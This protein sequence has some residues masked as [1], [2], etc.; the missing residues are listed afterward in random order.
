MQVLLWMP[1]ESVR[2]DNNKTHVHADLVLGHCVHGSQSHTHTLFGK[3][4]RLCNINIV[5]FDSR[6]LEI[7]K[8][9]L[10]RFQI[11]DDYF[12]KTCSFLKVGEK[13]ELLVGYMAVYRT[14]FVLS[15]FFFVMAL[16]TIG[17]KK[18]GSIR[19]NIH[20]GAWIWKFL[21]LI[22]IGVGVFSIPKERIDHFQL[23]WMYVAL[24]GAVA[25]I[26]IQLWLLVFFARSLGNKIDSQIEQGG[27]SCCWY[28]VSSLCTLMCYAIFFVGTV[29][30][31]FFF[32]RWEW[33]NCTTNKVF[34]GTNA[35]LCVI[36]TLLSVF[37]C[38]GARDIH[39]SLLQSGIIS[40]Y[41]TYL[42]WT[43]IS[44][45]PR[46]SQPNPAPPLTAS[47]EPQGKSMADLG[48]TD[49]LFYCGPSDAEF[50][51]NEFILPY[52]GV[53]I[54]FFTVVYSR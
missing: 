33:E 37:T 54:M 14:A 20:N 48:V 8:I 38:C 27:S 51:Y 35:A 47:K 31:F 45:A 50:A 11:P 43:A 29:I 52:V 19:A 49:Q 46:E 22:G 23:V 32:A 4:G 18:S 34:I 7:T 21:I 16:V 6:D 13:C 12:E 53:A 36:V 40:V 15:G 39:S 41:I 17:L 30:L 3:T 10:L 5:I 24:V 26:L 25:F 9:S 1:T 42:T 44:A 2:I 28:A